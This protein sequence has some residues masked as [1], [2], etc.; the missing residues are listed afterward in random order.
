MEL[1]MSYLMMSGRLVMTC[2]AQ[3]Y[4]A[5]FSERALIIWEAGLELLLIGLAVY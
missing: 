4:S 1:S 3:S 2:W 5:V